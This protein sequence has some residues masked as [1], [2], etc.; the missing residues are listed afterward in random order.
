MVGDKSAESGKGWF[1]TH[2][3]PKDRIA[4]ADKLIAAISPLPQ[5]LAARTARFKQAMAGLK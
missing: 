5:L 4:K 1:K 2:P 3:S